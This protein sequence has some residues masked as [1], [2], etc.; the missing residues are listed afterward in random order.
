[1]LIGIPGSGK[2][3]WIK[4]Q[5][6]NMNDTVIVSTDNII[7]ERAAAK[8]MTYSDVF[9][10]EIKSATMEMNQ[11]LKN[12]ISAGKN[13]VWDQTNLTK[14]SRKPKLAQFPEEYE[15]I[16]VV[17]QTPNKQELK[18]RLENRPGKIIPAN[19]LL[20]MISQLEM[21]TDNEGF[22]SIVFV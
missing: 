7:E 10:N 3:T 20:G 17:L 6:F 18:N 11:N 5:N 1:M 21:P 9:Q 16:A 4:N 12:A 13:I 2:S 22:H 8:G 15:K 19:V 14:K